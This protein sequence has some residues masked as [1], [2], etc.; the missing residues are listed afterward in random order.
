MNRIHER[1]LRIIYN[2]KSSSYREL[3]TKNRSVTIHHRNIRQQ[4]FI[5]S[6]REFPHHLNEVFVPHQCNYELR[7]NN[8]LERRRIK[9]VRFGT[10]SISSLALKIWEILPNEIKDLDT[11]QI[12]KAKIKKQKSEFQQNAL[13]DYAKSIC[14]KQHLIRKQKPH[15][16]ISIVT[17]KLTSISFPISVQNAIYHQSV[18]NFMG[19]VLSSVSWVAYH[20]AIVPSWVQNFFSWVLGGSE[21]F[22][23]GY[24]VGPKVSLVGITQAK[25]FFHRYFVGIVRS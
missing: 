10:K 21:N 13:A 23:R 25:N 17:V 8:Y 12:Y 7:E 3:L 6:C 1:A 2:D 11:L 5:K 19:L 20:C 24:F 4:E 22:S 15:I 9:L 16:Y 18:L 14:L